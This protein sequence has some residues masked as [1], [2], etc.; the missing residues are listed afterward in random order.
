MLREIIYQNIILYHQKGCKSLRSAIKIKK[1]FQTVP[2]NAAV[3]GGTVEAETSVVDTVVGVDEVETVVAG[4]AV[5]VD[6]AETIVVGTAVDVDE[7][8]TVVVGTVENVDEVGMVVAGTAMDVEETVVV[9]TVV[10]EEVVLVWL[11]PQ[12]KPAA[13][14]VALASE[15]N[16]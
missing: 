10:D 2:A 9:K 12:L 16:M 11:I 13:N 6:E 3:F 14:L 15:L 5:D 1:K 7:A 4:T 8:E